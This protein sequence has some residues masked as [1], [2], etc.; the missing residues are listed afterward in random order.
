MKRSSAQ[1][2]PEREDETGLDTGP[3]K[4]ALK[5]EDH[6]RQELGMALAELP[7]SRL[8][9]LDLPEDLHQAIREYQSITAHGAKKRQR[10]FLGRLMRNL[11]IEPYEQAVEEFRTGSR[12]QARAFHQVERWRDEL[13]A[14]DEAVTRW[15]AEHPETDSQQLRSLIRAARKQDADTPT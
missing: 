6:A 7:A 11:E 2:A 3:S 4:T 1:P 15:M 14:D 12:A 9:A 10:K 5:A 13:V 8:E